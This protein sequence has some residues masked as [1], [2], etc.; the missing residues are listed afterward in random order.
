MS[1]YI[2]YIFYLHCFWLC[3]FFLRR[4]VEKTSLHSA[5]ILF[6]LWFILYWFWF[7]WLNHCI[8]FCQSDF[9]KLLLNKF[10]LNLVF[11]LNFLKLLTHIVQRW[12]HV[13]VRVH[14][15]I[16]L[17]ITIF[18]LSLG[19]L[20]AKF[21]QSAHLF[22]IYRFG[23][24]SYDKPLVLTSQLILYYHIGFQTDSVLSIITSSLLLK[25]FIKVFQAYIVS[26][27]QFFL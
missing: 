2:S 8:W 4:L 18:L 15:K 20:L 17:I 27:F 25:T 21:Q 5:K 24:L 12:R 9:F 6:F 14:F 16:L 1:F 22:L 11:F 19:I 10:L 13:I 7:S 3:S 26:N 23:G